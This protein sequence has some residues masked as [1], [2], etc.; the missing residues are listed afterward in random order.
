MQSYVS[1]NLQSSDLGRTHNPSNPGTPISSHMSPSASIK[2]IEF[3]PTSQQ[4]L[5]SGEI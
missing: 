1:I 3:P 5:P 2:D 4:N